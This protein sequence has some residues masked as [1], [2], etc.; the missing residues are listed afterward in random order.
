MAK[1]EKQIEEIQ[2]EESSLFEA[3]DYSVSRGGGARINPAVFEEIAQK[4][5]SAL[6][7]LPEGMNAVAIP[8]EKW[9]QVTG[10]SRQSCAGLLD[11]ANTYY[12]AMKSAFET[13]GVKATASR[14]D[15][16][17]YFKLSGG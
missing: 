15:R 3:V 14:P 10:Q 4:A 9:N 12:E 1:K 2:E 8:L 5:R 6:E 16:K 13:Q 11:K 17:I 7:S